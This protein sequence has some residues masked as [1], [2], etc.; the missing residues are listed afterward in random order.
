MAPSQLCVACETEGR[1][2]FPLLQ[3]YNLNV[4]SSA[5][6]MT[7]SPLS[8]KLR[9]VICRGPCVGPRE[10]PSEDEDGSGP[11]STE[12]LKT[13]AGFSLVCSISTSVKCGSRY[14]KKCSHLTMIALVSASVVGGSFVVGIGVGDSGRSGREKWYLSVFS[15]THSFLPTKCCVAGLRWPTKSLLGC[16][17]SI[18]RFTNWS[19]IESAHNKFTFVCDFNLVNSS[20]CSPGISSL[21]R[22]NRDGPCTVQTAVRE[23]DGSHRVCLIPVCSH[24]EIP[25]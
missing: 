6:V 24:Y 11:G 4:S 21:G 19:R 2:H 14:R 9:P 3:L 16:G 5:A 25:C 12:P 15:S 17:R 23:S 1:T 13:F 20:L 10:T 8:S 7:N 18:G 22:R